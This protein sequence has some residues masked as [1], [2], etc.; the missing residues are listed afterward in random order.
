M[1]VELEIYYHQKDLEDRAFDVAK[2]L[3]MGIPYIFF[4]DF[5]ET[6]FVAMDC[7]TRESQG[8]VVS[9]MHMNN[10]SQEH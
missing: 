5:E 7:L 1:S 3:H 9:R 10:F 4:K 2:A 8:K 6:Y